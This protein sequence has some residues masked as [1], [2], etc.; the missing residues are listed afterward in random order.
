MAGTV[1]PTL[2]AGAR[3]K[4]SEVESKFDWI[5][6]DIVPMSGG[7]KTD[8]TYDL[9]QSA[10]RF[11]DGY[12]SRQW[13]GPAGSV[14]VPSF[15]YASATDNGVY[16]PSSSLI[17]TSKPYAAQNGAVGAPSITFLNSPTTG[18]YRIGADNL[19]GAVTGA[20]FLDVKSTGETNWPL[21][22]CFYAEL[23]T[24]TSNVTGNGTAYTFTA[25]NEFFDNNSDYDASTGKFTAPVT[26]IYLFR[27]QFTFSHSNTT[28]S[29]TM[30]IYDCRLFLNGVNQASFQT[31]ANTSVTSSTVV[32][33]PSGSIESMFSLTA[34]DT[35]YAVAQVS[36]R[37]SDN[38]S[39]LGSGGSFFMGRM[40]G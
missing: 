2:V 1:W 33:S 34:G 29:N 6:G 11:R 24:P 35:V 31:Y 32:T 16:F 30:T 39:I 25:G 20:K 36:S 13:L 19:G 8:A 17:S 22:P 28:T 15:S 23:S 27:A 7:T 9:G 5:E 38:V 18:F 21:Q 10:F 12:V 4:A 40:I 14:T 37:G 3:A 26:G